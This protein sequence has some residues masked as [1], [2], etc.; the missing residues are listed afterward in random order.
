[1]RVNSMT[2][3]DNTLW[4]ATDEG[5]Y[6]LTAN[7]AAPVRVPHSDGRFTAIAADPPRRRVLAVSDGATTQVLVVMVDGHA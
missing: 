7:A 1:M 4:L 2:A 3:F 5:I 6:R